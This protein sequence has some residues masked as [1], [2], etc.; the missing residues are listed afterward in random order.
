MLVQT[1]PELAYNILEAKNRKIKA[2]NG[3]GL[4]SVISINRNNMTFQV[5][6]L[7]GHEITQNCE[8][9]HFFIQVPENAKAVY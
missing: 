4:M 9:Y 8:D 7:K 2:T 5:S 3:G 6:R 1:T